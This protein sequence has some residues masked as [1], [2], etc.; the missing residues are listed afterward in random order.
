MILT[1]TDRPRWNI[2][3]HL[4]ID[5]LRQYCVDTMCIRHLQMSTYLSGGNSLPG[6]M[7]LSERGSQPLQH[8]ETDERLH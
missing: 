8:P 7:D 4:L 1:L 5:D 3:P 2:G 6:V